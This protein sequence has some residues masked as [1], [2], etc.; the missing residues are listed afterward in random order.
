MVQVKDFAQAVRPCDQQNT[1][2]WYSQERLTDGNVRRV[3][4]KEADRRMHET[5]E[6]AMREI[7]NADGSWVKVVTDKGVLT[8]TDSDG[9]WMKETYNKKGNITSRLDSFGAWDKY[10]YKKD[11]AKRKDVLDSHE[12][13]VTNA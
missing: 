8:Y 1:E 7:K 13:G 11:P 9:V 12:K 2:R 5:K 10:T 4:K 3:W 6:K